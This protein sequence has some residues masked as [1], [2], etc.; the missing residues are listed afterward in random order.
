MENVAVGYG[1]RIV[2]SKLSLNLAND[3]RIGLLGS[4]GNGKSTFAKLLGG[5]LEPMS[6]VLRKST[7]LEA[8]FFAQ[9][10]VDDLNLDDTPYR[11]VQRLMPEAPEAKVRARAAQ[12]GFPNVKADTRVANLSGGEKARLLMG[13]ATFNGPHLL[14]LDEPT[15]HLDI[16]SR[17]A[18]AEAIND[19]A[20]AVILISHDQYLLEACADRL[21]L[22][23]DGKVQAFDG[24]MA[25]YR[26]FVLDSARK[27]QK[28][29]AEKK[30]DAAAGAGSDSRRDAAK[31]R[32]DAA[33]LARKVKAAEEKMT[34]FADLIARVDL[35]LADP[36][37][38]ERSPAE[39]SKLSQQR[40]EL[41]RALNAAEEEWL[42]LS[43]DLEALT[44]G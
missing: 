14:I 7:K 31:A 40:A 8:G 25:D 5:R 9:H 20:G 21:W 11:A 27:S 32:K 3:D 33:P 37:A 13:L 39:A 10:Q 42:D 4:N 24:D 22:V 44:G 29:G 34:R 17:S 12:I 18:L 41:E 28:D 30:R 23:A 6:G 2:L 38:F 36:R 35:M 16:D 15:N 43:S 1:E 19:Y 26:K